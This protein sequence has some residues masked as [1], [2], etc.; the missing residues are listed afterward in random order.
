MLREQLYKIIRFVSDAV[1]ELPTRRKSK[2]VAPVSFDINGEV[3][4][5]PLVSFE[6]MRY[7]TELSVMNPDVSQATKNIMGVSNTT[8]LLE[9]E[10]EQ[11]FSDERKM[12]LRKEINKELKIFK[13]QMYPNGN[14]RTFID[15]C[16]RQVVATGSICVEWVPKPDLSGI[17]KAVIVP[18]YTLRWFKSKRGALTL[19]QSLPFT[20]SNVRNFKSN[21]RLNPLNTVYVAFNRVEGNP[22]GVPEYMA[23]VEPL[24]TQS[25]M[26][27]GIQKYSSKINPLGFTTI[28]FKK[29]T[30]DNKETQAQYIARLH[31]LLDTNSELYKDGLE[32]G[33]A[34]GFMD[35]FQVEHQP[36][37]E[38]GNN[39]AAVH[40]VNEEQVFS[41]LNQDPALGG[42]TYSTTE[43]YAGVV[44]DKFLSGAETKQVGLSD[45]VGRGFTL[46]LQLKGFPVKSVYPIFTKAKSLTQKTDAESKFIAQKFNH[47][48]YSDGIISQDVYAGNMGYDDPDMLE[49]RFP[50]V[51]DVETITEVTADSNQTTPT[52]KG[53]KD[54]ERQTRG[55]KEKGIRKDTPRTKR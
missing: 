25:N 5:K 32:N 18:T 44:Y 16:A 12:E 47:G 46:H 19:K 21:V 43:T 31:H 27:K 17:Q 38:G 34:V 11:D 14:H 49:P 33:L 1:R 9:I 7:M 28:R 24:E 48:L 52:P 41:A 42:R 23:V 2:D 26:M 40:Q 15:D 35:E 8:Y 37:L 4:V 54:G 39:V 6:I 13:R 30:K 51:E 45:V 10:Y 50:Y 3:E 20:L 53:N 29:P 55:D 22:Y 36:T